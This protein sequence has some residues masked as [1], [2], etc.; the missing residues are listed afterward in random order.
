V[1]VVSTIRIVSAY[2]FLAIGVLVYAPIVI[3]ASLQGIAALLSMISDGNVVGII[4]WWV[5][6]LP[7]YLTLAG[8]VAFCLAIPFL[9]IYKLLLPGPSKE[10]QA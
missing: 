7:L 1:R 3:F 4:I 2:T 9:F 10:I 6:G 8:G 5:I